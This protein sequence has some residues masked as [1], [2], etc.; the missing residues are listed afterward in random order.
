MH[1]EIDD[2][3]DIRHARRKRP[4]PRNGDRQNVLVLDRPLD[5][6]D[7]RIEALDVPDHER[8][9]GAAGRRD[10]GAALLNR[11]G[12]RLLDQKIDAVGDAFERDIVVHMGR[13]RDGHRIEPAAEQRVDVIDRGAAERAGNKIPLLAVRVGNSDQF[14]TGHV[15]EHPRMV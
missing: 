11:G 4:D 10:D 6:L 9:A 5:R 8:N 14:D 7:R 15:R 12:N 13:R 2:D 3:A 1:A